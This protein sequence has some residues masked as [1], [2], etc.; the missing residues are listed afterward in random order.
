MRHAL[1]TLLLAVL[2]VA[3]VALPAQVIRGLVRAGGSAGP[4]PGA[5]ITVRDSA[6]TVLAMTSSD[7]AGAWALKVRQRRGPVEL[8]VR[9]LG[10]EMNSITIGADVVADTLDYEFLLTEVAAVAEEVRV[11]AAESQN[12]KRLNEAYRRGWKV[13]DPEL[14]AQHRERASDLGQLLRSLGTASIY[15]PRGPNEC[16]R[17]TRNN[18]C[19]SLVVDGIV[20]GPTGYVLPSDIYFLAILGASEARVQFG[21][22]APWGAI[23]IYTRSY[24]DRP[25]AGGRRRP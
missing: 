21:D 12:E 9:R 25:G 24:F 20:L 13:F 11:T 8:R 10:F 6:G 14:V 3:P 1:R 15:I 18:Q 19:L 5:T 16:F 7:S 4:V 2:L 17:A 22:K 23:A